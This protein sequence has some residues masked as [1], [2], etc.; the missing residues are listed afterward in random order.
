MPDSRRIHQLQ[1]ELANL[2]RHRDHVRQI[3][4]DRFTP[5]ARENIVSDCR[6]ADSRLR[7]LNSQLHQYSEQRRLSRDERHRHQL[8]DRIEGTKRNIQTMRHNL[9]RRKQR[10]ADHDEHRRKNEADQHQTRM[11]IDR[12]QEELNHVLRQR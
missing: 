4:A 10:L 5:V 11:K 1:L 8:H 3:H 12:K 6:D 7:E 9:E 2:K